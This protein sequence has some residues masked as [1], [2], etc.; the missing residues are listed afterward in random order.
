MTLTVPAEDAFL[1]QMDADYLA[2][3][4]IVSQVSVTVGEALSVQVSQAK[5]EKCERCWKHHIKVGADASHPTLCPRCAK[6]MST[7]TLD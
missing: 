5:G 1:A 4:F 2:D 6:V 3:L 7:M